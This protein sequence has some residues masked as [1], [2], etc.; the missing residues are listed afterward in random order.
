LTAE[1]S[2]VAS[3]IDQAPDGT[4]A[5]DVIADIEPAIS[6]PWGGLEIISIL[7]IHDF[8]LAKGT[9]EEWQEALES[10]DVV[11][12]DDASWQMPQVVWD[13]LW[14]RLDESGECGGII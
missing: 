2:S 9:E 6:G 13:K 8:L 14:E 1:A 7:P 12:R 5:S 3:K 10:D 11:L 4:H